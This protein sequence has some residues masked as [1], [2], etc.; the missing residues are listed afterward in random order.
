[1]LVVLPLL[2]IAGLSLVDWNLTQARLPHFAGLLNYRR[3]LKEGAFWSSLSTTL[4]LTGE[5]TV[6][7]LALGTGI[8]VLFNRAG[9][10]WA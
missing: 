2:A 3:M 4:I 5:S 10:A 1:M 6:L 7:Q 8:A 9:P